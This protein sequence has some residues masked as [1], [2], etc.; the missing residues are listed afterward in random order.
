MKIKHTK[1]EFQQKQKGAFYNDKGQYLKYIGQLQ[2]HVH[3]NQSPKVQEEKR[4]E[5]KR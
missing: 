3:L 1:I 5:E 4:K 2:M